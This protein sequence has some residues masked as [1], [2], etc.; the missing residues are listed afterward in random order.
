MEV[1]KVY[2]SYQEDNSATKA[3]CTTALMIIVFV[4]L[5]TLGEAEWLVFITWLFS[6]LCIL[7]LFVAAMCEAELEMLEDEDE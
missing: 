4:V 7:A 1:K 5:K 3:L 2:N 6:L